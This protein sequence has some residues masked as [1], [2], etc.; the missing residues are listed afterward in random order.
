MADVI[1][2]SDGITPAMQEMAR[3]F[4]VEMPKAMISLGQWLRKKIA[5]ETKA[6]SPAGETFAPLNA[7]TLMLRSGTGATTASKRRKTAKAVQSILNRVDPRQT[8]GGFGGKLTG[9]GT[10]HGL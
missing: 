10:P 1:K 9:N 7:L 2:I 4:P 5:I 8:E 6:G 3:Q